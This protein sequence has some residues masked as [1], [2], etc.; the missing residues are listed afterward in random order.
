M[1]GIYEIKE[2]ELA[3]FILHEKSYWYFSSFWVDGVNLQLIMDIII[4]WRLFIF[5]LFLGLFISKSLIFYF[6]N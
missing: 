2:S 4:I 3:W 1:K 6:L 5:Y